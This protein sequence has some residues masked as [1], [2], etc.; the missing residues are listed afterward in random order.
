MAVSLTGCVAEVFEMSALL[1]RKD[2]DT[3]YRYSKGW[4][5]CSLNR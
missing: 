1:A 2:K 5:I 4:G 3:R